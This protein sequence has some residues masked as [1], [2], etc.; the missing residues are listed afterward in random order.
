MAACPTNPLVDEDPHLVWLSDLLAAIE[1]Q[2]GPAGQRSKWEQLQVREFEVTAKHIAAALND[3]PYKEI[4]DNML[5]KGIRIEE[6]VGID[7]KLIRHFNTLKTTSEVIKLHQRTKAHMLDRAHSLGG[8][9][10]T[11]YELRQSWQPLYDVRRGK[12]MSFLTIAEDAIAAGIFAADYSDNHLDIWRSKQKNGPAADQAMKHLRALIRNGKIGKHFPLLDVSLRRRANYVRPW[13]EIPELLAGQIQGVKRWA[14]A[15]GPLKFRKSK[16]SACALVYILR[17]LSSHALSQP[18][19]SEIDDL[20]QV[21]TEER[22]GSWVDYL[23]DVRKDLPGSIKTHLRWLCALV[24]QHDLFKGRDFNWLVL[25]TN[26]IIDQPKW[27]RRERKRKKLVPHRLLAAVPAKIRADRLATPGLTPKQFA[28]SLHNELFMSMP[29]WRSANHAGVN[30][31]LNIV[32]SEMT[33]DLWHQ[34]KHV[35]AWVEQEEDEHR[36]YIFIHFVEAEMKAKK[37]VWEVM[38]HETELVYFEFLKHRHLLIGKKGDP[39]TIFLGCDGR[40]MTKWGLSRLMNEISDRYLPRRLSHHRRRDCVVVGMIVAGATF[41]QI[42]AA[43]H[44]GSKKSTDEYTCGLPAVSCAEVQEREV[45]E[46]AV[47]LDLDFT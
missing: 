34:L 28:R 9:T 2:Y 30:L 45:A 38:D 12:R 7:D 13:K 23:L 37:E 25:K 10:C 43:L 17:D 16:T 22:V 21:I 39:G 1:L 8:W 15:D 26:S 47:E 11:Q 46:V 19:G 32:K 36:R 5:L 41:G 24:K 44:H 35:P 4:K 40:A 29:P 20:R 42:G 18:G 6:L 3:L 27:V 31:K 33:D 14:V